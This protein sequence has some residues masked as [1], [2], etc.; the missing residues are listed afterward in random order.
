MSY[1]HKIPREMG[2]FIT[3]MVL[4]KPKWITRPKPVEGSKITRP[5]PIESSKVTRPK[6]VE[7]SKCGRGVRKAVNVD[8]KS[9]NQ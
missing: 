3:G 9:G 2:P 7:S 5:K 4:G 6:P 8:V 1:E